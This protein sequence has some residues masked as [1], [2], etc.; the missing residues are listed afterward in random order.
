MPAQ[1]SLAAFISGLNLNARVI[2]FYKK[3]P[4]RVLRKK[5]VI[6]TFIITG[7]EREELAQS[8]LDRVDFQLE[9]H[10]FLG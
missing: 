5:A 10:G 1:I 6:A 3:S 2:C 8:F 4:I 9:L 7:P